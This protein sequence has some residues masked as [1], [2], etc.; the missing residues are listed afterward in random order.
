MWFFACNGL[1]YVLYTLLSGEWRYLLPNRRSLREAIQVTLYDLHLSKVHPPR[2]KFN[3][4]QQIAYTSI[5]L[6]GA[7]SLLR[8]SVTVAISKSATE[9]APRP[10]LRA[11][12]RRRAG[13]NVVVASRGHA[14]STLV[15]RQ[16]G[17][18]EA[19]GKLFNRLLR[20]MGLTL[21][22]T[23]VSEVAR[24][25]LPWMG[26]GF[27]IMVITGV[28][29]SVTHAENDPLLAPSVQVT[30][31]LPITNNDPEGWSQFAWPTSKVT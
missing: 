21:G 6:M 13:S 15:V 28:M 1:L 8:G 19:A 11:A 29:L 18:R 12:V 10:T 26:F 22:R 20:L 25:L 7:G 5:I 23:P 30:F 17:S 3:G 2:R 31:V 4:A 9:A 16:P 27:T 14:G 24:R